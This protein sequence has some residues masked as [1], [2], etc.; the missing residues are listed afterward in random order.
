MVAQ[1]LVQLD[2][3]GAVLLQPGGE[4]LVQLRARR[5]RQRVV[6]SVPDQQVAE[7]E[8]ILARELRLVGPDELLADERGEAGV[9]CVSSGASA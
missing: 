9:T 2:E 7:A 6:G 3:L 5:L 8:G 4:A 1:D